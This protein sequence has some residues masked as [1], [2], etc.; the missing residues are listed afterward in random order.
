MLFNVEAGGAQAMSIFWGVG[1]VSGFDDPNV[2]FDR[3]LKLKEG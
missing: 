2:V 1:A 3:G